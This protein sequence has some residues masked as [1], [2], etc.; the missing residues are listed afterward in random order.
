MQSWY[1][2]ASEA[3]S[4]N[5]RYI[6]GRMTEQWRRSADG[7]YR[8][9]RVHEY[10][11]APRHSD[12]RQLPAYAALCDAA[13]ASA[14]VGPL[15]GQ[16][17]GTVT[18]YFSFDF[19]QF[20][21]SVLPSPKEFR[22][23][24]MPPFAARY[25]DLEGRL[26]AETVRYEIIHFL[27]NV[28]FELDRVELGPDLVIERL[29]PSVVEQA[30]DGCALR[31]VFGSKREYKPAE[32]AAFGLKRTVRAPRIPSEDVTAG[33]GK[34]IG[35][36][37]GPGEAAEAL[38]QCL[39]LM[40]GQGVHVS[41][42]VMRRIDDDFSASG[43]WR[44][45][46]VLP[47]RRI[48]GGGF[49]LSAARC[50]ELQQFWRITQGES[51][52]ANR[53]LALAVRRLSFAAQRERDEDR[54]MDILIAAEAFYLADTGRDELK[55][56]LALRAAL[57]SDSSLAGWD[58][59]QVRDHMGRAYDLRSTVAHGGDPKP[60][61]IRVRGQQASL[62][63]FVLATEDIV[64]HALHKA[65]HQISPGA[66]RSPIAWEDLVL[67]EGSGDA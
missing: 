60:K 57:W 48:P 24:Q 11:W 4:G 62:A 33:Q 17:P 30:L 7:V 43:D 27:R 53:A 18:S 31:L 42:T 47:E 12:L 29:A 50:A 36:L 25:D 1:D 37:L 34:P 16:E 35:E 40:S 56:R 54:L 5:P 9:D 49:R 63:E 51:F 66:G 38:L 46:A 23:G 58:R 45:W 41:G 20:A 19:H 13:A 28:T 3:I 44:I 26:A 55:Y 10:I 14:V 15:V 52:P 65:V 39:A 21:M 67:P 59:R 2:E 64:R 61:D 8:P 32:D 6:A 22:L